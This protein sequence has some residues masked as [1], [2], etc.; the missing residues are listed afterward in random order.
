M[1]LTQYLTGSEEYVITYALLT[2]EE[3]VKGVRKRCLR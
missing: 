1:F 3:K 2:I